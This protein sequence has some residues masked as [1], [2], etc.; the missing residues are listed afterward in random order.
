MRPETHVHVVINAK[1]VFFDN[2][3]KTEMLRP[4]LVELPNYTFV[5]MRLVW[6]KL[7]SL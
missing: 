1:F 6:V 2:L 7:K 4:I 3:I 5:Y